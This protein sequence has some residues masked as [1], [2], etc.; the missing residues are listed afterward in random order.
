MRSRA[1][2]PRAALSQLAP[3]EAWT[4]S[5]GKTASPP[6]G[7]D[8]G[9]YSRGL[10]GC[11]MRMVKATSCPSVENRT[12]KE[13]HEMWPLWLGQHCFSV[14]R[15]LSVYSVYYLSRPDGQE[16]K[17]LT[18]WNL[19]SNGWEKDNKRCIKS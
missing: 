10:G 16:C 2:S 13:G 11:L 9:E 3:Q 6:W 5:L 1:A 7:R 14:N 4:T 8:P 19:H 15:Y 12:G 17:F 18:P